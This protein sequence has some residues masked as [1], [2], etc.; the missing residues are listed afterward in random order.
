MFIN[1]DPKLYRVVDRSSMDDIK[2]AVAVDEDALQ[3]K[4]KVRNFVNTPSG[5][6]ASEIEVVETFP[7]GI[8]VLR[9]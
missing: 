4:R 1:I 9:R 5:T 2:N 6:Q 3:V 7:G 8:R